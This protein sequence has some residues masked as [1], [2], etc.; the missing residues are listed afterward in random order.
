MNAASAEIDQGEEQN[1]NQP[2]LGG[3][4]HQHSSKSG[5]KGASTNVL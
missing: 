3:R 5:V 2:G 4:N 1:Q